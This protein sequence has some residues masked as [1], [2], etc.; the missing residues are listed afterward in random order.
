MGL[1]HLYRHLRLAASSFWWRSLIRLMISSSWCCLWFTTEIIFLLNH[2]LSWVSCLLLFSLLLLL[3]YH[4]SM[5]TKDRKE[6]GWDY[7]SGFRR[8]R[9]CLAK[10]IQWHHSLRLFVVNDKTNRSWGKRWEEM[11]KTP[12]MAWSSR[13]RRD[14]KSVCFSCR[15]ERWDSLSS[16]VLF[17][18]RVLVLSWVDTLHA[19]RVLYFPREKRGRRSLSMSFT[20]LSCL[21][22]GKKQ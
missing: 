17:S 20:P 16:R 18:L 4:E 9:K 22:K 1:S 10:E 6:E 5:N 15:D 21:P 7:F 14:T 3:K 8:E 11:T 13:L 19:S 12:V 2:N